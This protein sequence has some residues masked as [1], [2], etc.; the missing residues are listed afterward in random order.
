MFLRVSIRA[1][2]YVGSIERG[3]VD[4]AAFQKR[5]PDGAGLTLSAECVGG[6]GQQLLRRALGCQLDV[7]GRDSLSLPLV[8]VVS[9]YHDSFLHALL[10]R[11]PR[12]S[13]SATR[14]DLT[15]QHL[16]QPVHNHEG[17]L[18]LELYRV[19]ARQQTI[20]LRHTKLLLDGHV[21]SLLGHG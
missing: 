11:L 12:H 6:T 1:V 3:V 17:L 14:P 4:Q 8:H 5:L 18:S 7:R 15:S 20:P 21:F 9:S 19:V 16:L 10:R 2:H 13:C